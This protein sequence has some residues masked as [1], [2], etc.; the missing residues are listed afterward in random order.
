MNALGSG[1]LSRWGITG[2]RQATAVTSVCLR[3]A[4]VS[5]EAHFSRHPVFGWNNLLFMSLGLLAVGRWSLVVGYQ[6][7]A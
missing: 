6:W 4:C 7:V 3:F 2:G 1:W 5:Y